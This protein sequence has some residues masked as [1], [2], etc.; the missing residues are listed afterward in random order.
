MKWNGRN[1]R[2][3][4]QYIRHSK[5]NKE[6]NFEDALKPLGEKENKGNVWVP[7][8]QNQ[9]IM[10]VPETTSS[11]PVS[12]TPTPSIT[13]TN[14][15]TPTPSIT[16]TQT[17]TPSI[18]P[19]QTITPTNTGTPTQTPTNTGTPTNTPTNTGS[20][21]PTPSNLASGTTEANAYLSAVVSAGGTGITPT[22]SAAT[23]TLFT[24]LVSN[25][26]YNKIVAMYPMLGGNSAGCK[27]NAKNPVDT[28][29]AMRL[30]FAGGWTFNSTGI[31]PNGT[32]AF[33]NTFAG[34][35]TIVSANNWHLSFYSRTS[36]ARN[37]IDM[38][39]GRS[40]TGEKLAD[41]QLRT[42]ADTAIFDAT[43]TGTFAGR[44][45]ATGIT[46]GAGYYIGSIIASNDRKYYR[47]GSQIVSS[48][49]IINNTISSF[50][51]TIGALS[52]EFAPN[53]CCYSNKECSFSTIG[54]GL[55]AGEMATLS[56]IVNTWAT[57]IGRNTY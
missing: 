46:D 49:S 4:G 30:A 34:F 55:S 47:N 52:D 3:A 2:P 51:L 36:T 38:G 28:N 35:N 14:T 42:A 29:A 12:P 15:Q 18:T 19:T 7:V 57:A 22:I 13:P 11:V 44:I 48:T 17:N 20:P 41:L 56:T 10:N 33:A 8:L 53:I 37:G 50:S 24:S 16:P 5:N 6:F 9:V 43:T 21:T 40:D 32:N 45:T 54:S 25:G 23:R 39:V 27:F 26:L 1:Y 31:L